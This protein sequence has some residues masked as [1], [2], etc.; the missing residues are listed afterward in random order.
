MSKIVVWSDFLTECHLNARTTIYSLLPI[1]FAFDMRDTHFWCAVTLVLVWIGG[2]RT[3][4]RTT[5]YTG[6]QAFQ[7]TNFCGISGTLCSALDP[8]LEV[9]DPHL[10]VEL[11]SV[12]RCVVPR[13][14]QANFNTAAQVQ[15]LPPGSAYVTR[16]G[17][18][19]VRRRGPWSRG[20]SC[21]SRSPCLHHTRPRMKLLR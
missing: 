13:R 10:I 6:F 1:N 4:S 8:P 21:V 15:S 2:D 3:K 19:R 20:S 17:P 12:C 11:A 7:A 18:P 14:D 16:A 5:V 9:L